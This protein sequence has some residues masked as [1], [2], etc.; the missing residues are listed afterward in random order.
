AYIDAKPSASI[1][2]IYTWLLPIG[3]LLKP[4]PGMYVDGRDLGRAMLQATIEKIRSRVIE[5]REIREIAA[6]A[7]F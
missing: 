4:F 5:N 1:P 6:R 7:K 2:R 3:K